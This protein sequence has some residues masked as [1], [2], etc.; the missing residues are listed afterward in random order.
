MGQ[1][2]IV[3]GI[4]VICGAYQRN[5]EEEPDNLRAKRMERKR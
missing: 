4:K 1:N 5:G 2:V 3:L